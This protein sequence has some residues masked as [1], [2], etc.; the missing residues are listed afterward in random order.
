MATGSVET[1]T[2][3]EETV[4]AAAG[5]GVETT[6]GGAETNSTETETEAIT[7]KIETPWRVSKK[8]SLRP[9]VQTANHF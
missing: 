3:G 8:G 4:V 5:T 6:E 2:V 7:I 1:E 9:F